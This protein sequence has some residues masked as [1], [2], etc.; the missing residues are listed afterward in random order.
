MRFGLSRTSATV[1]MKTRLIGALLTLPFAVVWSKAAYRIAQPSSQSNPS[2]N[3]LVLALG[4]PSRADGT[5][6]ALQRFH[7]EAA[8]DTLR[9]RQTVNR[10][11]IF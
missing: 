7:V 4:A 1:Q 6:S 10:S 2:G 5:A 8:V 11:K 9:Q 3:C